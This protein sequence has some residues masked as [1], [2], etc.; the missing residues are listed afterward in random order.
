MNRTY[1]ITTEEQRLSVVKAPPLTAAGWAVGIIAVKLDYPKIPGNVANAATFDFAVLYEEVA[2]PIE[3]LFAGSPALEQVVVAAAKRLEAAGV[4][5]IIG[6]CGFFAHF[7]KAVADAVDVP[8]YLSSL[9]QAPL[10]LMGLRADQKL[11]VIAADGASVDGELLAQ[12]GTAPDRLVV[13]DVGAL[14]AFAPIRWGKL[15][16]DNGALVHALQALVI[17]QV[18]L[19]PEVGA[20][21]LECSDLP[22]YAADIQ[23]ATGLPVFDFITLANWAYHAVS[24]P[25]YYGYL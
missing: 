19:H 4:R 5:V 3:D 2:F 25:R 16:L 9:C 13:C 23:E 11:L 6:A 18:N 24:Q 8:V 1:S 14:P 21:L 20:I 15:E 7:Q 12:V 10:A 17:E 22:P